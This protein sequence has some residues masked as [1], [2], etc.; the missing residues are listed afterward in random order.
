MEPDSTFFKY[1]EV[2]KLGNGTVCYGNIE[3]NSPYYP[4]AGSE[5][6]KWTS[7][8]GTYEYGDLNACGTQECNTE[9]GWTSKANS[10]RCSESSV[11]HADGNF[12]CCPIDDCI[13]EYDVDMPTV[14][15]GTAN[16]GYDMTPTGGS[17][18]ATSSTEGC[19]SC[20]PNS[21]LFSATYTCDGV[22]GYTTCTIIFTFITFMII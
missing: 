19:D 18:S 8:K 9:K 22:S 20:T 1:D 3:C 4:D 12:T 21:V 2:A 6:F 16:N 7:S 14:T 15:G 5:A 11:E 10:S 17:V 13:F